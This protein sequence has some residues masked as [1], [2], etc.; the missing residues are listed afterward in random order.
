MTQDREQSANKKLAKT[1]AH[2]MMTILNIRQ[3]IKEFGEKENEALL[4]ELSHLH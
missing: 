2:I 4:N 1:H 3:C